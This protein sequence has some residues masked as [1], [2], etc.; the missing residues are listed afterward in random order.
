VHN[1]RV[2]LQVVFAFS[3][4]GKYPIADVAFAQKIALKILKSSLLNHWLINN[5]PQAVPGTG[6]ANGAEVRSL[7][8][9]AGFPTEEEGEGD[10]LIPN[11]R[12]FP[13]GA[14]GNAAVDSRPSSVQHHRPKAQFFIS[15]EYVFSPFCLSDCVVDPDPDQ[16]PSLTF[17]NLDFFCFVTSLWLFIFE[18]T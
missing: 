5:Y 17:K 3:N 16:D 2:L 6:R 8:P 7:G 12:S 15:G 11:K 13:S 14:A 9:S 4:I 18:D 1:C 10:Q